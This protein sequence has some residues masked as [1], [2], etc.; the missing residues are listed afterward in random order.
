LLL[1]FF[2]PFSFLSALPSVAVIDFDSGS[3]CTAQEASVMTDAFRN[4]LV[5][6]GRADVVDRNHTEARKGCGFFVDGE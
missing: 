5:R 6:A 1:L 3:F 4:E 2:I